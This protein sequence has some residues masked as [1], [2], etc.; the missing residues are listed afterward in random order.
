M[1]KTA[2]LLIIMMLMISLLSGCKSNSLIQLNVKEGD[3][4][5]VTQQIEQN[6]SIKLGQQGINMS[7]NTTIVYIYN[8]IDVAEDGI[9]TINVK[10]DSLIEKQ[11]AVGATL[12]FDSTK[13]MDNSTPQ[14]LALKSIIGKEFSF[15]ISREGKILN[16]DGVNEILEAIVSNI[17]DIDENQ[18]G[19]LTHFLNQTVGNDAIKDSLN[20]SMDIYPGKEVKVGDSWTKE[21]VLNAAV[22]MKINS[23][24][25]LKEI[26][27]DLVT[28][29][30]NSELSANDIIKS[31]QTVGINMNY[32]GT[33][34]ETKTLKVSKSN[35]FLQSG[36]IIQTLSGTGDVTMQG[37]GISI[38]MDIESKTNYTSQKLN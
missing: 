37:K 9:T 23:A 35:G 28:I 6:I 3:S 1:K 10:Y 32:N 11:N 31:L 29:D 12:D 24:M 8:I 7:G 27:D 14:N 36:D 2:Y 18:K 13:D 20:Q 30:V 26:K 4:Y 15:K 19:V 38:P 17:K 33:G 22:P 34:K 5:K 25:T 16:I 21:T